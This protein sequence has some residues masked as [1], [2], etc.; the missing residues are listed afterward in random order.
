MLPVI[1]TCPHDGKF[2]PS[3]IPKRKKSN[4]PRQCRKNFR[5]KGDSQTRELTTEIAYNIYKFCKKHVYVEIGIIQR[6]KCD[7]NRR[8]ECAYEVLPAQLLYEQYHNSILTKIKE[9]QNQTYFDHKL[10]ILID[11]HGYVSTKKLYA[12]FIIGTEDGDTLKAAEKLNI[13]IRW[14]PTNGFLT[15]LK[16]EGYQPDPD[17]PGQYENP[18]Y[19]GGPTVE[20]AA[21]NVGI[22]AIQCEVKDTIRNDEY[23]RKEFARHVASSILKIL[24]L[25]KI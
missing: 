10:G 16:N 24:D 2:G 7:L 9:I 12:D 6:N 11:I 20:N 13:D 23:K 18:K 8:S 14:H 25:V 15:Y 5:T 21:E 1:L 4:S 17:K 22:I 3:D 19:T